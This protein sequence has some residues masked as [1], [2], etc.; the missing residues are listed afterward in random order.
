VNPIN[1]PT[2]FDPDEDMDDIDFDF[3][4]LKQMNQTMNPIQMTQHKILH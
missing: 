1:D 2:P 4:L 3:S